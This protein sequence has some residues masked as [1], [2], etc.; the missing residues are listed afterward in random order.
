MEDSSWRASTANEVTSVISNKEELA[1][2]FGFRH[3]DGHFVVDRG[4]V[5]GYAENSRLCGPSCEFLSDIAE[6][7]GP[8]LPSRQRV[9]VRGLNITCDSKA[10][11]LLDSWRPC[12]SKG[13]GWG[14]LSENKG[15]DVGGSS[16]KGGVSGV[17]EAVQ[18]V[19]EKEAGADSATNWEKAAAQASSGETAGDNVQDD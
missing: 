17:V 18:E 7:A 4:K 13:I 10:G 15:V 5:V 12:S 6:R 2:A 9:S 3:F 1:L 19:S 8:L 14:A 11:P 16:N